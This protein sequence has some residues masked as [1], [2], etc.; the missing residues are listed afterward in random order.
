MCDE[1]QSLGGI[2]RQKI[3]C[4]GAVIG[5][6]SMKHHAPQVALI[7]GTS[8]TEANVELLVRNAIEGP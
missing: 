5:C 3:W 6:I 8:Q 4:I 7:A 1:E 2:I